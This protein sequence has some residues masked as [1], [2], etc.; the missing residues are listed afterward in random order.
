MANPIGLAA[1]YDKNADA[2]ESLMAMGFGMVEVGS[3]TPLPQVSLHSF[4]V[5]VAIQPGNQ[6]PRMFRLS[7]DEAVI[8]RYGFNSIGLLEVR[9]R[10]L[11]WHLKHRSN[12][13]NTQDLPVK[14]LGIN[15]GKNKASD[16]LSNQDYS[17]GIT[18][19]G[20]YADYVVINISSPNTPGLRNLQQREAL[21]RLIKDVKEAQNNVVTRPPVL[22]KIAP[23]L[24]DLEL[25]DI[26]RIALEEAVDG[27]IISNTTISRP[28]FLK[29][30]K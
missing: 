10:L 4:H 7:Q 3:V 27:V 14:L 25:S 15:L 21:S 19:L 8:N 9:S 18:A 16:A 20:D 5:T 24:T 6:R 26:A 1:G 17:D 28:Q 29:S 22:L 30:R 13:P 11:Q 12:S 2:I 23:D